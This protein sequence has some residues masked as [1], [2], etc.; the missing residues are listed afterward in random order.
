MRHRCCI[1]LMG[2]ERVP[3][4]TTLQL[5]FDSPSSAR[6]RVHVQ[7]EVRN[8]SELCRCFDDSYFAT[9]AIPSYSTQTLV[10]K[11]CFSKPLAIVGII[12]LQ[13]RFVLTERYSLKL[14]R[15]EVVRRK[16][17]RA[18]ES[19]PWPTI[20]DYCWFFITRV[21][22]LVFHSAFCSVK[23][24]TV[25]TRRTALLGQYK[26]LHG[27]SRFAET[28]CRWCVF[29]GTIPAWQTW[30]WIPLTD[31]H[32]CPISLSR[33]LLCCLFVCLPVCLFVY[34][35]FEG[36]EYSIAILA[37]LRTAARNDQAL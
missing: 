9:A 15:D 20:L 23:C 19:L 26:Q 7:A 2:F 17:Q 27:V 31:L 24:G 5:C 3:N 6:C 33:V 34:S 37:N 8:C 22:L 30:V 12:A 36:I 16:E 10:E 1:V 21:V 35:Y 13:N 25:Q 11:N 4:S 18:N 32:C 28:D 14:D 29:L